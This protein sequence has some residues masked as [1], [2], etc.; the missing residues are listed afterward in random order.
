MSLLTLKRACA[1]RTSGQWNE[2]D[3][4]V[5]A[6]GAVVGCIFNAAASPVATSWRWTHAFGHH[7]AREAAVAAFAK[8]WW[9]E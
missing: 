1:S 3:Y 8:S 5:L 6:D 4:D 7:E 2:D 9:R